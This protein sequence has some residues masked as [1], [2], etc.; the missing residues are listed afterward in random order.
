RVRGQRAAHALDASLSAL[1]R[2]IVDQRHARGARGAEVLAVALV[3]REHEVA[4]AGGDR[5][6][7]GVDARDLRDLEWIDLARAQVGDEVRRTLGA[8]RRD[9][10]ALLGRGHGL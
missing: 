10:E 7:G 9:V 1:L 5:V 6:R 8:E 3:D 2:A 4:L